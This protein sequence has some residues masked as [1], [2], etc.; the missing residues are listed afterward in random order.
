VT[1]H[2]PRIVRLQHVALP[3]PGTPESAAA[4]RHFYGDVLGLEELS[5]PPTLP[6]TVLWW[7]AGELEVHLFSEPSGVAVN[8]QSRR[9]PCLQVDDATTFRALLDT[10][11]V[12][13]VD[14]DGEIPGRPRFFARDPFGNQIEFVEFRPDHW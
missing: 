3:Y 8:D 5:V 4:A 9:H 12:T 10:S 1:S 11:G 2:R 7:A 13:T 14:N 6:G